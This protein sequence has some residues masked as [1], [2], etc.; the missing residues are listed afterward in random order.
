LV[1][2]EGAMGSHAIIIGNTDKDIIDFALKCLGTL[3]IDFSL[4]E[5]KTPKGKPIWHIH[6]TKREN[7]QKFALR[8]APFMASSKK[9]EQLTSM[10]EV[11]QS[12]RIG[13]F[14]QE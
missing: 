11:K 13:A 5:Y 8:V 4:K 1:D 9:K 2:G 7:I 14:P 6:I 10:Y 3:R 12:I